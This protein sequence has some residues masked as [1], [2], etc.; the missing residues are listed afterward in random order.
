MVEFLIG[1]VIGL[2]VGMN[3]YQQIIKARIS[4]INSALRELK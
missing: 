1:F 2:Y 3:V 4:K